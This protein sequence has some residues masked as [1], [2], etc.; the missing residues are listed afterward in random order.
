MLGSLKECL[1][2][3]EECWRVLESIREGSRGQERWSGCAVA[4]AMA[5]VVAAV[6][7]RGGL[8]DQLGDVYNSFQLVSMFS[9]AFT[10]VREY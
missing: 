9:F 6:V 10:L 1:R 2:A 8:T 7:E 4:V 3:V 5:A